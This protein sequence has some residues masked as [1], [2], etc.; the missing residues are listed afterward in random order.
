MKDLSPAERR[1]LRARAHALNP[2]VI[3]GNG[4]LTPGVMAE[5]ERSLKAH[6]LIKIRVG[7]MEHDERESACEAICAQTGALPIQHIGKVLVVYRKHPVEEKKIAPRKPRKKA[8]PP[9]GRVG[10]PFARPASSSKA[11][12]AR[13]GGTRRPGTARG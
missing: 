7:G 8:P 4:G 9:G 10:K 11:G 2:V 12:G 6:E 1:A 5:V 13:S 3:I